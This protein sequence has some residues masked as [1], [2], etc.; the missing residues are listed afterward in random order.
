MSLTSQASKIWSRYLFIRSR[1]RW[2][3][4]QL[5]YLK[6]CLDA[7]AIEKALKF[8]PPTLNTTYLRILNDIPTQHEE[9]TIRILQ[10]LSSAKRPLTIEELV[11]TVAVRID[12]EP[13]FDPKKRIPNF[14]DVSQFCSSL[15]EV[16]PV[17]KMTY[18]NEN[19]RFDTTTTKHGFVRLAHS[20]V[21]SFLTPA[22]LDHRWAQFFDSATVH[23]SVAKTCLCYT[24]EL[25]GL[26]SSHRYFA[27]NFFPFRE[28]SA[29]N[30]MFH[31]AVVA[32]MDPIVHDLALKLFLHR[33]LAY[34]A[35]LP[36]S[37]IDYYSSVPAPLF[38]ACR[39][40]LMS[41]VR[42][43]L[44]EGADPNADDGMCSLRAYSLSTFNA[45]CA[46][47][48]K[49]TIEM[50]SLKN[51]DFTLQERNRPCTETPM[52]IACR[53]G[54]YN[55]VSMLLNHLHKSDVGLYDWKT[56]YCKAFKN[57]CHGRHQKLIQ[58]L[59]TD[60][61]LVSLWNWNKLPFNPLMLACRADYTSGLRTTLDHLNDA[62]I[63]QTIWS[64]LLQEAFKSVGLFSSTRHELLE[65]LLTQLQRIDT[66]RRVVEQLFLDIFKKTY[67]SHNS[68][69]LQVGLHLPPN[70]DSH[71]TKTLEVLFKH[72]PQH[73]VDGRI[74]KR[75]NSAF[76]KSTRDADAD[77]SFNKL[78]NSLLEK[79]RPST[80]R[81]G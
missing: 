64:E 52:G 8:L 11:D 20:S 6:K 41:V 44:D 62:D 4:C 34:Q 74:W 65:E 15:V 81:T 26:V 28:Y 36:Y 54:H 13:Y 63:N 30:W 57:A 43:F 48:G 31:A 3:V 27:S 78:V 76:M 51:T 73:D 24:I 49:E 58:M 17:L 14:E 16:A 23:A 67:G 25:G 5:D 75:I 19:M 70:R 7:D 10:L 61:S 32:A 79:S 22:H 47:G 77:N 40:G 39:F 1:F 56:I 38:V 55:L 37:L 42:Y 18:I 80:L 33:P 12:E 46:Q 68:I 71:I 66:D 35:W 29:R 21:K 60:M 9:K 45:A 53:S 2:V 59:L 72:L 69:M 50:S